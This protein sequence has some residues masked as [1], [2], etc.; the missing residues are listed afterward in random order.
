MG[1]K[2]L[3]Y[4]QARRVY[5]AVGRLQDTQ[6]FY[7]DLATNRLLEHIDFSRIETLFEFGC[8]TGRF[9]ERLFREHLDDRATYRG[10]DLSPVMVKLARKRLEPWDGRAVVQLTEGKP[11]I[12]APDHS[13]DCLV[14]NFVFDLL[15][16]DDIAKVVH[17]AHRV[18]VGDGQLCL[19]S[20][21]YGRTLCEKTVMGMARAINSIA[22]SLLGGCRTVDLSPYLRLESWKL[23]HSEIVSVYGITSE[24]L[25]ARPGGA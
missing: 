21:T 3:N 10:I 13:L 4:R 19:V 11:E 8:G 25:V 17:E 22:P 24:V 15:S 2:T 6:A 7:E 20:A 18:L 12:D 1:A 16:H 9:A 23:E 14:S 5:N